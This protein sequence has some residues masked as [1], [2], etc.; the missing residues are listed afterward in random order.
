VLAT[1]TGTVIAA[2][3]DPCRLVTASE[4][5]AALGSAPSGGKPEGPS[6]DRELG[7]KAWSC[8]R[9]VGKLY[10]SINVIEFASPAA[11]VQ[12]MQVMMKQAKGIPEGI[13]LTPASEVG[14]QAVWGGSAEGAMWIALRSRYMLNVTLAGEL[15]DPGRFREPLKRLATLAVGR[16]VP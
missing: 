16:I 7:A 1:L 10:L 14:D 11:A 8:D 15:K 3:P 5:T 12:G 4:I 13:R 9:Q 2:D 6:T